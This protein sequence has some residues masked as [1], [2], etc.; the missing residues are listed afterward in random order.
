MSTRRG[1]LGRIL[2]ASV[3]APLL[4]GMPGVQKVACAR[5]KGTGKI[6]IHVLGSSGI[7]W[8]AETS[9]L[10]GDPGDYYEEAPCPDCNREG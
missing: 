7:A 5:C 3:A 10:P 6:A 4:V 9:Y 8:R 1:F 2:A